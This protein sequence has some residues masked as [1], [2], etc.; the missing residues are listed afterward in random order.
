MDFRF[1]TG[2]RKDKIRE[3]EMHL[4][5]NEGIEGNVF[6]VTGGAGF[7][8]SA[9]CLELVRRGARE[10]RSF[11]LRFSSPWANLFKD[12]GVISI[13][14]PIS[15]SQ[16]IS[17]HVRSIHPSIDRSILLLNESLGF[18]ISVFLSLFASLLLWA[19]FLFYFVIIIT[20]EFDFFILIF[21]IQSFG[22]GLGLGSCLL[23][24]NSF[25]MAFPPPPPTHISSR[26]CLV[27][28]DVAN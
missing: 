12:K 5:E 8:G 25:V 9:L 24:L 2:E 10:V 28:F 1:G 20:S 14:G 18:W 23:F 4:S 6:V 3:R 26:L 13:Q 22:D 11:D 21:I 7:V 27:S 15:L 16:T 17:S 19:S